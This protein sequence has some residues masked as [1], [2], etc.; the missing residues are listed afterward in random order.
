M[1]AD[2]AMLMSGVSR[3]PVLP[4]S[5]IRSRT[6]V[7]RLSHSASFASPANSGALRSRRGGVG[8]DREDRGEDPQCRPLPAQ[9]LQRAVQGVVHRIGLGQLLIQCRQG[10][11]ALDAVML[12]CDVAERAD[13]DAAAGLGSWAWAMFAVI[14][15]RCPSRWF[16]GMV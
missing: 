4:S 9:L 1:P 10:G 12:G 14:H 2:P 7:E 6:C 8:P 15:T 3:F 13:H 5:V 11:L 16:T